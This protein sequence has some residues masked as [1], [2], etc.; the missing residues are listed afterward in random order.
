MLSF[1]WVMH[2]D[3]RGWLIGWV[4]RRGLCFMLHWPMHDL[5]GPS[6]IKCYYFQLPFIIA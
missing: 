5:E 6:N 1:A 3:A 4:P 2:Y